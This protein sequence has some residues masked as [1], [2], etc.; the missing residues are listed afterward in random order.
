M[1]F[2]YKALTFDCFGTLMDWRKGQQQALEALPEC[3]S[4]LQE[5]PEAFRS[6]DRARMEAE[7]RLQAGRFRSYREILMES[8]RTAAGAQN[9]GL[10][11]G[12]L[13]AYADAMVR[14]PA[15]ADS[16]PALRQLVAAG[17]PVGFL[18]NCD[19]GVLREVAATTLACPEAILVSAEAVRSYKPSPEAWQAFLRRSNLA[20]EEVLHVSAY[21]FYDLVPARRLGF[22]VAFLRRDGESLPAGFQAEHQAETL[23][24]LV[25]ALG[26]S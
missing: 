21:S 14:W 3:A 15:F 20:P 22:P 24:D 12:S 6:L 11:M 26:L 1:S 4:L 23:L 7:Q 8:L 9:L 17:I 19:D 5:G 18:S 2:P 16:A 10:S 25:S 13:A